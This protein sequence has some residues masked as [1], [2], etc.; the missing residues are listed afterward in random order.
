MEGGRRRG[1]SGQGAPSPLAPTPFPFFQ[2]PCAVPWTLS[3]DFLH[4]NGQPQFS[5][6]TY[7]QRGGGL[8][9]API[10]LSLCVQLYVDPPP[11]FDLIL[12]H[13]PGADALSSIAAQDFHL[14][15]FHH[16]ATITL[17]VGSYCY[18]CLHI[19]TLVLFSRY[20]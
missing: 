16:V 12:P 8:C 5:F 11:S 18:A 9:C 17:I 1:G 4:C 6:S 19:G 7:N 20:K 2:R 15:M 14:M 13:T 10:P 3:F